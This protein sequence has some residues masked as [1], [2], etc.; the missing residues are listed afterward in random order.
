[1]I[2]TIKFDYEET[3]KGITKTFKWIENRGYVEIPK[4][5]KVE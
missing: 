4:Y 2:K 3:L 5:S 1:M